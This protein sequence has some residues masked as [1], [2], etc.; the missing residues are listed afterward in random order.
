MRAEHLP[1]TRSAHKP[2]L[3]LLT[4]GP[5]ATVGPAGRNA[6]EFLTSQHQRYSLGGCS[7]PLQVEASPGLTPP[8]LQGTSQGTSGRNSQAEIQ[9]HHGDRHGP[10]G[11]T[12]PETP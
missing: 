12:E 7:P 4:S 10:R 1:S 8:P 5:G 2:P 11:P 6:L 9:G 3:V